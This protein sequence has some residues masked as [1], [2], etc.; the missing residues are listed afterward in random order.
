V[1]F[2]SMQT[3]LANGSTSLG[4]TPSGMSARTRGHETA[5][6]CSMGARGKGRDV[7]AR[8][9]GFEMPAAIGVPPRRAGPR[10]AAKGCHPSA[11]PRVES[12][13]AGQTKL[14]KELPTF[15]GGPVRLENLVTIRGHS[16]SS[17]RNR[18]GRPPCLPEPPAH[19][20]AVAIAW[21]VA[22]RWPIAPQAIAGALAQR[23]P[24]TTVHGTIAA[25]PR[26]R[27]RPRTSQPESRR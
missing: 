24:S 1:F 14:P 9:D 8:G 26:G 5:T 21:H 18:P 27:H 2:S 10:D 7:M 4:I 3:P 17:A 19:R 20:R 12:T 15:D 13:Q 22:C 6:T 25:G 23:Y 16:R 11:A